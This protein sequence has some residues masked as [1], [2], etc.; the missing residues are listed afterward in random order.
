MTTDKQDTANKQNALLSTGA[1]TDEG[2]TIVSKNAIKHGIFTTDLLISHGDGKEDADEY[3]KLL[4]GLID[5]FSPN[6]QMEHLLVEKI[7]VDF[8]RLK[9]VL[10]FETGSLRKYLDMVIDEYYNESDWA[11]SKIRKTNAELDEE[12]AEQESFINWNL[13]Y[14]QALEKGEVSFDAPTWENDTITADITDDLYRVVKPLKYSVL[15][16]RERELYDQ[17]ELSFEQLKE[18]ISRAE[19]TD[20][21]IAAALIKQLEKYNPDYEKEI[22]ALKKQ[23]FK[24]QLAEEIAVS[25]NSLPKTEEAEKIMRYER[26][27]QKS[28][29]QNIVILKQLQLVK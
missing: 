9:R 11:G 12:I 13:A 24:N 28:I 29:M 21:D 26:A 19:Y 15:T 4:N 16:N 7:A 20:K 17:G 14:K 3:K 18:I 6:G 2:K 8:W 25:L 10:R 27:L 22:E 5:S 23:K 1:I